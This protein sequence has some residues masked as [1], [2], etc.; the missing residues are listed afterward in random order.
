[1]V[2]RTGFEPI[3]RESKSLVLDR[4]TIGQFK[5][6]KLDRPIPNYYYNQSPIKNGRASGYRSRCLTVPNGAD[7]LS[8]SRPIL[9]GRLVPLFSVK[10]T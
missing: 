1:M 7:Y 5:F 6:N 8:S 10:Q 9:L 3:Q 4:Y 2:A